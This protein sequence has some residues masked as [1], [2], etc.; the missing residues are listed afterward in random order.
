MGKKIV[1]NEFYKFMSNQGYSDKEIKHLYLSIKRMDK[2]SRKWVINWFDGEDFPTKAIE[3]VTAEYLVN[4][5]R[6]KPINAFIVL[7]WLKADPQTA[8]YFVLKK[9]SDIEIGNEVEREMEDF[10]KQKKRKADCIN[11][12]TS[13]IE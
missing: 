10:L 11:I 9:V 2:E 12:D 1:Y 13:D 6:L 3:G 8:K 4:N 7:D 5:Y